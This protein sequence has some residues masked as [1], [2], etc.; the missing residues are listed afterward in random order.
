MNYYAVHHVTRFRYSEPITESVME[1]R[2]KP[3]TEGL[4]R[5]LS[6]DLAIKPTAN[7]YT[8]QEYP[9]NTVQYFDIPGQ[10]SQLRITAEAIVE[11][12][13][14]PDLPEALDETA[15]AQLDQIIAAGDYWEMLMPSHFATATPLLE[16]LVTELGI[17]R[18]R[19]PLTTLRAMNTA[20]FNALE[21]APQITKVDSP[22]DAALS[23]RAGVCQDFSHIMLTMVR[24]LRI[25]C[26]YVSGYLYQQTDRR[27]RSSDGATHAWVEALLPE[28]G[29][30]GFDPTNNLIA[31]E[32]HIR[33]AIGRDYAD[34]PPTRGF[35]KGSAETELSVAVK[36]EAIDNPYPDEL[37]STEAWLPL[38]T[39][40]RAQ[41]QQQQQQ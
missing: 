5:C 8:Y 15:W 2:M 37:V 35:F 25:P 3:R 1:I 9:G 31:A 6:F 16:V 17:Q 28:L 7:Q 23:N 19:D 38:E 32:R 33:V 40:L 18:G 20:L 21:Y 27:D 24:A 22:I 30:V 12:Q 26:R 39:E 14:M 41:A 34:V 10:H 11:I 4:Q 29:W 36:V 13:P